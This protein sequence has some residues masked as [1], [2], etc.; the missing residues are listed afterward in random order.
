MKTNQITRAAVATL[1]F[2]AMTLS[3]AAGD[4]DA[5]QKKKSKREKCYG[6]VAKGMNDCGTSAHSCAGQAKVDNHPEE[7]IYLEAGMC[8]RLAGGSL[9]PKT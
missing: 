1:G 7:W 3:V 6:V 2:A 4:A 8:K 9:K 5:A